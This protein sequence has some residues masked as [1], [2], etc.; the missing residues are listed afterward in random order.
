MRRIAANPPVVLCLVLTIF[1]L[2]T[3]C[4]P[5]LVDRV[6]TLEKVHNRGDVEKEMTFFADD[7]IFEIVGS[8]KATGKEQLRKAVE[9]QVIFNSVMN[10]RDCQAEGETVTCRVIEQNDLLKAAGVGPLYYESAQYEFEEGLIKTIRAKLSDESNRVTKE[11]WNSFSKWA[12]ENRAQE[13]DEVRGAGATEE[14]V[15]KWL[16]LAREWRAEKSKVQQ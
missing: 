9:R 8:G 3:S 1:L 7:V 10:V 13:W 4:A 6:K 2:T 15:A 12:Y 5:T 14:S 16:A 11:F